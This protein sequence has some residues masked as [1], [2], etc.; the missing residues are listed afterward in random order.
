MIFMYDIKDMESYMYDFHV[1]II[2]AKLKKWQKTSSFLEE[3]K[4]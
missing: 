4:R 2:S 3:I 1:P